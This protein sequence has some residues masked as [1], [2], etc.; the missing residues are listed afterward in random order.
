MKLIISNANVSLGGN[1]ILKNINF[2]VTDGEKIAVIGRNG[3]GK[4]TLLR[5]IA[6]EIDPD[7]VDG[8]TSPIQKIGKVEI[9]YLKQISFEDENIT[10][11][12]EIK[13]IFRPAYK[14]KS[15]IGELE[16]IMASAPSEKVLSEYAELLHLAEIMDVNILEK[17]EAQAFKSFGFVEADKK[18]KISEF[19]GGQKTRI[20]L[21]KLL[22]SKPDILILDEP[23]NHL[24]QEAIVWL[25]DYLKT[26]KKAVIIVSHDREFIDNTCGVVYEIERGKIKKYVGN[27]SSF[28][29]KK[30]EELVRAEK[31]YEAY[32]A[33]KAR[34]MEVVERFRYKATKA[35]MAQSKLKEIE[36][37][38]EPPKP[39]RPDTKSFWFD[40]EPDDE[41]GLEV[42]KLERLKFGYDSPIAEISA[43]IYKGDR[44][45]VVGENGSGKSTLLKT[46]MG[47][48]P[49]LGGKIK[50]GQNLKV[51][52][53]DQQTITELVTD[54][55]VLDS[56]L[57]EF[58]DFS[59]EAARTRLGSFRFSGDDVF[60]PVRALSGG[61]RVRL[62]L[63]KIFS[64]KP[65]VLV[66]DEPTNHMDIAGRETL[67]EIL[68]GFAGTLVF[69]SHDRYFV[70][71]LARG[72]IDI[73]NGS[74]VF[75]PGVNYG[76]FIKKK[77]KIIVQDEIK[78]TREQSQ[79]KTI[80]PQNAYKNQ[81]E[82]KKK[83]LKLEREIEKTE[84][85]LAFK[86]GEYF[87]PENCSD[88]E[89]LMAL[90]EEINALEQKYE[91]ILAEWLDES[92]EN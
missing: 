3:S 54:D 42:I 40:L 74:A 86:R 22:F 12:D 85:L 25:E 78:H 5:L 61:E 53:F 70:K 88:A 51:G 90:S 68:D 14:I 48:L 37:M 66:L 39:E 84:Q 30:A 92:G 47:K 31:A 91:Q 41:T 7:R 58:P 13:N 32:V 76:E 18:K 83:I 9:G 21:I 80:K 75:Y 4:T 49:V 72:I 16:N 81:K 63:A 52:Y 87:A 27:Y 62:A 11:D 64:A 65:N 79:E 73:S 28:V 60:K 43:K 15:R 45:A 29:Q 67:E 38:E 33:E 34:L 6:G 71:K 89:K 2:E 36:R 23:T 69:V 46:I 50:F 8:Q 56:F 24:D 59:T 1:E 17:L 77:P 35:A 55:T 26:Y 44:I 57:A 10:L 19:S 82:H 20:A